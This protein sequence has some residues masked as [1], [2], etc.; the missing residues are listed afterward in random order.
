SP[1]KASLSK[2]NWALAAD[3]NLKFTAASKWGDPDPANPTRATYLNLPPHR[4][5]KGKVPDGGNEVFMD[6]SARWIKFANM[7][8][9]HSF[10]S[11]PAYFY[12]DEVDPSLESQLP[13]LTPAALQ[14]L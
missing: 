8:Y 7:Y 14:D 3:A 5:S 12:Q 11:R 9:L 6:G 4:G 2:G 10:N 1:V 13:L